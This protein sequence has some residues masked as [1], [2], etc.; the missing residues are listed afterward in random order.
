M[1]GAL[2]N[3]PDKSFELQAKYGLQAAREGGGS[4]SS[5]SYSPY[6]NY[7]RGYTNR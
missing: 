1:E 2:A 5:S 4:S 7:Y 3:K 6:R